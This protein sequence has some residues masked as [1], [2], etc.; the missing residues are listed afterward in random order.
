VLTGIA[1]MLILTFPTT[2]TDECSAMVTLLSLDSQSEI[3]F[4]VRYT[5]GIH[6]EKYTSCVVF[7]VNQPLL[8]SC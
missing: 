2:R 1:D 6:V 3:H 7:L 4:F 8:S 5:F